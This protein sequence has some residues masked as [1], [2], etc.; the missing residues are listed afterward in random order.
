MHDPKPRTRPHQPPVQTLDARPRSAARSVAILADLRDPLLFPSPQRLSSRHRDLL[1]EGG[2]LQFT[3]QSMPTPPITAGKVGEALAT[4][5]FDGDGFDE[6]VIGSPTAS[7]DDESFVGM[8]HVVSFEPTS[9]GY[10][11]TSVQFLEMAFFVSETERRPGYFGAALAAGDLDG[12]GFD[13]LAI[14][15]PKWFAG[16]TSFGAVAV[17]YGG[18]LGLDLAR[19]RVVSWS[20]SEA[21]GAALTSGDFDGDGLEDLAVGAPMTANAP[22]TNESGAI[23]IFVDNFDDSVRY[24]QDD[25]GYAT[26]FLDHFG[27][28]MTAGDFDGDGAAD[29][30]VG[31]PD[32]D[33]GTIEDAGAVFIIPGAQGT[34]P[35]PTSAVAID[36]SDIAGVTVEEFDSFGFAACTADLNADGFDDLVSSAP[37]ED[38]AGNTLAAAGI[39]HV[40]YGSATG[41]TTVGAQAWL[42]GDT[43]V[44][45]TEALDF[46]GWTLAAGDFDG[47]GATDLIA[48]APAEDLAIN[49]NQ[50]EDAGAAI[51]ILG[52]PT[53][54][55]SQGAESWTQEDFGGNSSE[56]EDYA[57]WS[58]TAGDFNQDGVDDFAI[59]VPFD[60]ST[61]KVLVSLSGATVFRDGFESGSSTSWSSVTP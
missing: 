8:V 29:L 40:L 5:D 16:P 4:G 33:I 7:I 19:K 6:L 52:S 47:D 15:A 45:L 53:G 35:D 34:G 13:D 20:G 26:E 43:G 28:A 11:T 23:W 51:S 59:G 17:V 36:Q 41:L 25:L 44:A 60:Q 50:V 55:V 18:P 58:L 42:Q 21:F 46:F 31:V 49:G 10:P 24:E 37:R 2:W 22:G 3:R 56:T 1:G 14:G 61:S 48:G 32:E 57:T 12:D 54:L 39:V 30:A 38:V 9:S 27:S